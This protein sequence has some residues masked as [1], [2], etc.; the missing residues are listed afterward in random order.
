MKK[1]LLT[2]AVLFSTQM[3]AQSIHDLS[4]KNIDGEE[5]SM[6]A[7]KGKKILIVNVASECG[8]TS[9]YKGLQALYKQYGEKLVV[10]GFPSNE[11]GGQEP[12]D[13]MQIKKFCKGNY[14][15]TFPMASKV[16]VKK[17]KDQHPIYQWLTHSDK[18]GVKSS[19]VK[20]N[21]QKYLIDENGK[22]VDFFY[23]TTTPQS[24]AIT[25]KI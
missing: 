15:V 13:E 1:L 22:F 6:S 14:N 23:S 20:W 8:F 12:G 10:L 9:Q 5:V 18:N 2:L 17:V 19:S 25:S 21:F 7:Y 16:L 4:Y 3:F 11:F 24:E